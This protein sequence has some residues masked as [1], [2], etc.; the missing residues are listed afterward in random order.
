MHHE[1]KRVVTQQREPRRE[2][3]H[4]KNRIRTHGR[5]F[6]QRQKDRIQELLDKH[7]PGR[8]RPR[9][10][11]KNTHVGHGREY[12]WPS[13]PRGLGTGNPTHSGLIWKTR[14]YPARNAAL[15]KEWES[16]ASLERW[17]RKQEEKRQLT[18][19]REKIRAL[20]V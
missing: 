2:Y 9:F 15:L 14:G 12:A 19:V 1:S 10:H 20:H 16:P 13:G 5:M 11:A 3:L 7:Q 4:K 17:A 8:F 6:E 18:T